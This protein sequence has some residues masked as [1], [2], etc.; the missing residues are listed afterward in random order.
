[1]KPDPAVPRPFAD[2]ATTWNQRFATEEYIFGSEPN[3]WLHEHGGIFQLGQRVLCMAD[4]EG[5]NSVWLAQQGLQVDAYDIAEQGLAKARRLAQSKGVKVNYSLADCDSFDHGSER[6]D[7]AV[8]IFVQFADP[9][10]R[11]RQF[12]NIRRCL[13]PGGVL[14]LLGYTPKQL[15]YKTGGPGI[16]SH[17]YTEAL[18]RQAFAGWELLSLRE[19]EAELKEGSR[20]AGPSALIGLVA[21]KP[22]A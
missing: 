14:I 15:Q 6:Y 11:E 21:R 13:K 2:A 12:A 1:M 4:G 7:G 5:R 19:Y 10:M 22:A 8:V 3:V 9:A 16:E 17:L 18:L 20:H